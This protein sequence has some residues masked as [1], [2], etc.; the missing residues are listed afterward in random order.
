MRDVPQV[1]HDG[2]GLNT[3]W[4]DFFPQG[5]RLL[6]IFLGFRGIALRGCDRPQVI[7][8]RVSGIRSKLLPDGECL[9][10][11]IFSLDQF[12]PVMRDCS[13][14]I[15]KQCHR[16]TFRREFPRDCKRLAIEFFRL[17]Q[18]SLVSGHVSQRA[19]H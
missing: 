11:V 19:D 9:E 12:P 8:N 5:Q 16:K 1:S 14:V 2:C 3:F 13:E 17:G 15:Q 4:A 6:P 18:I 7:E 10:I